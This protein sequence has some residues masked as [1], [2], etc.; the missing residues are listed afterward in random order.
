MTPMEFFLRF[1]L[2]NPDLATTIVGTI[3]P[4]HLQ[5]I[6]LNPNTEPRL[7]GSCHGKLSIYENHSGNRPSH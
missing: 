4:A 1:T 7:Y 5:T 6:G 3:K 2:T